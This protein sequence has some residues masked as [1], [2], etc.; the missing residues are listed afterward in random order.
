MK[1]SQINPKKSSDSRS[2]PLSKVCLFYMHKLNLNIPFKYPIYEGL[3][4]MNLQNYIY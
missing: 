4:D 3:I 1:D 2:E